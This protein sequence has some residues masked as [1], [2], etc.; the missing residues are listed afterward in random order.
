ML[1]LYRCGRQAEA[2]D[3]YRDTRR[4]LVEELGIEPGPELQTLD[5]AISNQDASLASAAPRRRAPPRDACRRRPTRSIGR[6]RELGRGGRAARSEPTSGS[7][8]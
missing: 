7:S 4:A 2:L 3:V 5:G 1:A 8:P 6:E